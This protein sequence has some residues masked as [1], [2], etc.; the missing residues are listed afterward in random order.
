MD[1]GVFA[2]FHRAVR[3]KL[4]QYAHR[5]G[6]DDDAVHEL[7]HTTLCRLW[8]KDKDAPA[9]DDEYRAL[10][11]LCFKIL[12]GLISN[13]FRAERRSQSLTA[14]IMAIRQVPELVP[15]IA[16][17]A[18]EIV[19]PYWETTLNGFPAAERT[20]LALY[21]DGYGP[22]EIAEI[23]GC[24]L[25]AAAARLSRARR[26]LRKLLEQEDSDG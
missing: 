10:V 12:D 11:G 20:A 6:L 4:I 26:R 18:I 1:E 16:D 22:A 8:E 14:Q 3:P 25:S 7:V 19:E 15:D 5:R 24:S 13:F 17:K 2:D 23:Q 21:R 9:N